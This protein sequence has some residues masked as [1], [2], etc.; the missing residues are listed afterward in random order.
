MMAYNYIFYIQDEDYYHIAFNDLVALDYTSLRFSFLPNGFSF[1]AKMIHK[2]HM[3]KKIEKHIRIPFR[4]LWFQ[5]YDNFCFKTEKPLC[6]IFDARFLQE[7][8]CHEYISYLKNRYPLS[9]IV[10]F[11]LDGIESYK[12]ASIALP[13]NTRHLSDILISFDKLDSVIYDMYYHPSLYSKVLIPEDNSIEICDVYFVG[14]AKN[15]LST[16][17]NIYDMLTKKG[18]SCSF[19]LTEVP[20]S[21]RRNS[22][23]LHYV[24]RLSY[25]ENLQRLIKSKAI[26]EIM[27][28]GAVGY[29][30]RLWE[31]LA[32]DKYI[33]TDNPV[34]ADDPVLSTQQGIFS[35]TEDS[36]SDFACRLKNLQTPLYSQDALSL[37]SP[38]SFLLKLDNILKSQK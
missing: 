35:T 20:E 12:H 25:L 3:S 7:L 14:K 23:G 28:D 29:T 16:I 32:Y 2:I 15:R 4:R 13:E 24:K 8:Y 18:L 26:L 30:L 31:S 5:K 6:F 21:R 22:K 37:F 34:I 19:F 9:K 38:V 1:F 11:Y 10:I 17:Y 36:I 33:I 27:R